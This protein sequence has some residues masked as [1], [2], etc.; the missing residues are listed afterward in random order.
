MDTSNKR[1]ISNGSEGLASARVMIARPFEKCNSRR[2]TV[3]YGERARINE[4]INLFIPAGRKREKERH[5]EVYDSR[6]QREH[7]DIMRSLVLFR[8]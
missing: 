4:W 2:S 6:E 5:G 8:V 1:G 3:G 7:C